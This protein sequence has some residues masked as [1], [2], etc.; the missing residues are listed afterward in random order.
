[1]YKIT[2]SAGT[3]TAEKPNFIKKHTNGCFVLCKQEEAE[4][5][6]HNG[7]PYLFEDGA[8]VHEYDAGADMDSQQTAIDGI[9][10]TI[11]EG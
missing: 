1:M 11:L 8:H 5:V 2:T 6:A 9:I 7:T 10:K 4:G 3:F